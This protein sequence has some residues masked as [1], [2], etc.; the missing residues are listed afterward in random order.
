MCGFWRPEKALVE[1]R[2]WRKVRWVAAAAV[3]MVLAL[4]G[5]YPGI[6]LS[7]LGREFFIR[8]DFLLRSAVISQS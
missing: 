5:A 7:G 1:R 3:V 4:L 8:C 6:T 2:Y